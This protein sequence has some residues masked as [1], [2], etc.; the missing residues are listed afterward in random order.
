MWTETTRDQ[1]ERQRERDRERDRERERETERDRDRDRDRER[2]S[3]M[4]ETGKN[5]Q[6]IIYTCRARNGDSMLSCVRDS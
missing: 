6:E 1:R 3:E 2:V 5:I 4:R